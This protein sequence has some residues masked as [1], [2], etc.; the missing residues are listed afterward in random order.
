MTPT[1][2][3]IDWLRFRTKGSPEDVLQAIRPLYGDRGSMLQLASFPK[4]ILGFQNGAAVCLGAVPVARIDYGGEAQRGWARFD[5]GGKG[6]SWVEDWD[7]LDAVEALPAAE[8]R[9]VDLALTTW[10]G[11]VTHETVEAAHQ[12]GRFA[13]GGR[14]P[15]MQSI[16][17]TNPRAGRTLN[18][19]AREQSDKFFRGYEKGFQLLAGL[20]LHLAEATTHIE[21][22]RVEDIY[23]C[24]VELKTSTRPIPFEVVERRDQYF[25][26][27]YPFCADVLPGIEADILQRRPEREPQLSLRAA[28]G[29]CQNQFGRT[30]FTALHAYGGDY[31]ALLQ[32]I[33]GNE[34]NPDLVE[35]GVLMTEH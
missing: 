29:H 20:P 25:A 34:H 10:D 26:G 2:T 1:K 32:Q 21:G 6:C 24:E 27:S 16:V 9:R 8:I 28:L 35:A 15:H 19:G 30:L 7:A 14:P 11:E 5:M 31:M 17:S 3:T 33:I 4:G 12:A 22:K 13:C 18:V 23:R